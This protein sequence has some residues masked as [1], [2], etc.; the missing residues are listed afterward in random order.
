EPRP[1]DGSPPVEDHRL[2]H[3]RAAPAALR[4]ALRLAALARDEL[5]GARRTLPVRR[6]R[7]RRAPASPPR[8][9]TRRLGALVRRERPLRVA[10]ARR[11]Q[12]PKIGRAHVGDGERAEAAPLLAG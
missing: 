8:A 10:V 5:A 6:R 7:L 11:H 3:S 4:L 1:P 9:A 2:C 12:V